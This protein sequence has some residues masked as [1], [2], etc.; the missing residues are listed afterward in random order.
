MLCVALSNGCAVISCNTITAKMRCIIK[1]QRIRIPSKNAHL[2]KVR[3]LNLLNAGESAGLSY[4]YI[5][6]TSISINVTSLL[7]NTVG[8][9]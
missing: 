3:D 1:K 8:D 5:H 7:V 2:V 6:A 9:I 4:I